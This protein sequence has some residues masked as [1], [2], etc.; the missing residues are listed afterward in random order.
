MSTLTFVPGVGFRP[1]GMR[2]SG[3]IS[4]E[5]DGLT[6][7]I[8]ELLS[9]SE[10]VDLSYEIVDGSNGASCV[11]PG[12]GQNAFDAGRV[13]LRSGDAG[14]Q[15]RLMLRSARVI[16]GGIRYVCFG[17][18]LTGPTEH[19]ELN[20]A[21]GY[22]GDWSV[23][24]ELVAF[25]EDDGAMR[26]LH[27]SATHEGI[28]VHVRGMSA[29]STA[30]ALSIEIEPD[31]RVLRPCGL[32]G[33]HSRRDGPSLLHLSDAQ[34]RVYVEIPQEDAVHTT[35]AEVA[36]FE[37][38]APDA[39]ELTLEV[40]FVYSDVAFAPVPIA[41]PVVTPVEATLGPYPIRVLSTGPSPDSLRRRNFGPALAVT[42]DLGGWRGDR[43]VLLPSRI[44]V[45]GM[46]RG[47][48]YGN[49]INATDPQPIDTI[50]IR[51][52]PESPSMVTFEGATV[53]VR[54]PWSVRFRRD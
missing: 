33:L 38:V 37:P 26:P 14:T 12:N 32:G 36:V 19:A 5:R 1:P 31:E 10:G 6:L 39:Q 22:Y 17:G 21:G 49:G 50:E 15:A 34:G 29:T 41:L 48:G 47:I 43:R 51:P 30:T 4:I 18:P 44:R 23:P 40:P 42:L 54:G 9:T 2:L 3:P 27:A 13:S 53:Q 16:S 8:R 20:V 45:D 46:D 24:V 25:T 35:G 28:T 7:R 52:E 11:I